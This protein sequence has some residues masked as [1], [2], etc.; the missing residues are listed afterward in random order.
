M[1][2]NTKMTVMLGL[3][4]QDFKAGNLKMLQQAITNMTE[5]IFNRKSQ[6]RVKTYKKEA[7]GNLELKNIY[8]KFKKYSVNEHN[9]RIEET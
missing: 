7:N 1:G 8:S 9:C 5:I 3:S 2:T 4:D 6:Q